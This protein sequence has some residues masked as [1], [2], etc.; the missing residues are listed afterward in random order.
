M[1]SLKLIREDPSILETALLH[2]QA[3]VEPVAK[4]VELD[5]K[6]RVHKNEADN[7]KSEKN[8]ISAK[9]N[10]AKGKFKPNPI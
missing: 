7:L 9:I 6:W 2:R 5:K 10:E 4:L 1:L 3:S 8:A